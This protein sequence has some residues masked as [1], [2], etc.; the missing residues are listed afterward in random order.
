MVNRPERHPHP[1]GTGCLNGSIR[2]GKSGR[3]NSRNFADYV[4]VHVRHRALEGIERTRKYNDNE[5]EYQGVLDSRCARFILYKRLN[6]SQFLD[7][8]TVQSSI[9]I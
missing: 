2:R 6:F 9:C 7:F 8:P 1:G 4:V 5:S 3:E